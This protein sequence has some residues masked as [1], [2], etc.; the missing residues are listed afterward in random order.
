MKATNIHL[1]SS[2]VQKED[3]ER[4][5]GHPGAVLFM[6]GYSASG[7]STL[8]NSVEVALHARGIHSYI[9]DGDNV[10]SGLNSNL[11]FTDDDRKENIRRIAEVAKLFTDAGIV[12][13]TAFISPFIEDRDKAREIIGEDFIEVFVD[14]DLATCEQRDPKGLYKKARAGEIKFFTGIDS[15]YEAPQNAELV[16]NTSLNDLE[17]STEIVVDYIISKWKKQI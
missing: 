10:R 1:H 3:R 11:G 15:K 9:L 13:L 4:L 12:V 16:V 8:A 17:S 2:T 5:N 14:A 6:T 7:K